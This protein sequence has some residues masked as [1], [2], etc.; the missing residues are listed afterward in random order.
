M[1]QD[2][3]TSA[4]TESALLACEQRLY[5]AQLTSDVAELERLLADSLL[6]LGP[7]GEIVTKQMDLELHRS[8]SIRIEMLEP[9]EQMIRAFRDSGV[10]VTSI[11]MKGT[12]L[13]QA[14]EGS[15]RYLRVW[16][17]NPAG[18][19]VIAGSVSQLP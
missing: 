9:G 13:G 1:S 12:M 10:V 7:K 2:L 14:F 8:G 3:D 19:Q 6:F 5:A 17:R 11:A 4:D 16:Q 15:L 18:W